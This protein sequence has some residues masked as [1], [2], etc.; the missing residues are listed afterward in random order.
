MQHACLSSSFGAKRGHSRAISQ[1][2][3]IHL[4]FCKIA[5]Q[6]GASILSPHRVASMFPQDGSEVEAL[7]VCAALRAGV[8]DQAGSVQALSN[9]HGNM[10]PNV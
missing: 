9:A 6:Q 10:W 7:R 8:A 5:A 4:G 2:V 1:A 3:E